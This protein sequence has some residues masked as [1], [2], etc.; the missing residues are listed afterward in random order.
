M[1]DKTSDSASKIGN[2]DL[3]ANTKPPEWM[4]QEFLE[5]VIRHYTKDVKAEVSV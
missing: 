3:F 1:S 2:L 5:T 4:N